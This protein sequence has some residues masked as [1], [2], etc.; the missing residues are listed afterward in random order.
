MEAH[1]ELTDTF[2]GEA[3]YSWVKR[4]T[5]PVKEETTELSIVRGVKKA[6]GM[7]NVKCK[8]VS[9]WNMIEL[10]PHGICAVI[11]ITFVD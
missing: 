3:N 7:E 8:R 6:L 11:F 5:L 10:R 2:G 9:S 1:Y 4:G